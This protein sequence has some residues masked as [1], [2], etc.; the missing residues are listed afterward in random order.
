MTK[1]RYVVAPDGTRRRISAEALSLVERTTWAHKGRPEEKIVDMPT[2]RL[3][4][5]RDYILETEVGQ[6]KLEA[7]ELELAIREQG[8]RGPFT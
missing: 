4:W 1:V 6:D 3:T 2:V 5:V 7:I 8:L